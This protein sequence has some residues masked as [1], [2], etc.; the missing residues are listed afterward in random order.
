MGKR[1]FARNF[2]AITGGFFLLGLG[3]LAA[4]ALLL[5]LA[6]LGIGPWVGGAL[7]IAIGVVLLAAAGVM[8]IRFSDPPTSVHATV[9]V[10]ADEARRG[11]VKTVS[12]RAPTR[13]GDCRGTGQRY[14]LA[15][16]CHRCH[17]TGLDKFARQSRAVMIPSGITHKSRVKLPGM[18]GPRGPRQDGDLNLLVKIGRKSKAGPA[19]PDEPR[20]GVKGCGPRIRPSHERS[21][22][23]DAFLITVTGRTRTSRSQRVPRPSTATPGPLTMLNRKG[24]TK[25]ITTATEITVRDKWPRP[26]GQSSWKDRIKLQWEDVTSL[27]LDYGSHDSVQSLWA[28]SDEGRQRQH[29]MDS[30]T[31]TKDQWKDLALSVAS[32]TGGRLSIDLTE[33]NAPGPLRDS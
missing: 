1:T 33:L 10:T 4:G 31:F 13:C 18:G 2:A 12:F 15:E 9:T 23:D 29:I 27:V 5:L 26:G 21:I 16:R 28:V 3:L 17:G 20:T 11:A 30:R 24:D 22:S 8:A 14:G 6:A 19:V 7:S 32:L 25:L